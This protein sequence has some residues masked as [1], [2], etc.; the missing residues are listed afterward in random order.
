MKPNDEPEARECC[1]EVIEEDRENP[2][3]DYEDTVEVTTNGKYR[4]RDCGLLFDTLA[5]HDA[6]HR[7]VLSQVEGYPNQGMTM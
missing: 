2:L 5:E 6:H 1:A 4:W 3:M 7:R